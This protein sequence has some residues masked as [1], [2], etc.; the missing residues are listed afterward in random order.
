MSEEHGRRWLHPS[1][2]VSVIS[3]PH[4]VGAGSARPPLDN[5]E[6]RA[7]EV[8]RPYNNTTSRL[9]IDTPDDI[10]AAAY[11]ATQ[12]QTAIVFTTAR[13]ETEEVAANLIKIA[14]ER[15]DSARK[16]N[17]LVHHGSL[18]NTIR[19]DVE[20]RLKEEANLTVCATTTMELG[21]DIGQMSR[22]VQIGAPFSVSSFVQRLGRSGRRGKLPEMA[23]FIQPVIPVGATLAVARNNI[24]VEQRATARV[25]PTKCIPE[26][27]NFELLQIIA[28]VELHLRENFIEPPRDKPL[29]FSL[30]FQQTL[31]ILRSE[32]ELSPS[33]LARRVLTLP[34]FSRVT[35]EHFRTLLSSMRKQNFVQLT[36]EGGILVGEKGAI[37]TE[38]FKFYATFEDSSDIQVHSPD[39]VIGTLSDFPPEGKTFV[40]GGRIWRAAQVDMDSRKVH[41]VPASGSPETLWKGNSLDIHPRIVEK[42]HDILLSDSDVPYLLENARAELAQMREN[43]ANM[44]SDELIEV[45]KSAVLPKPIPI[46]DDYIPYKDKFDRYLPKS[47]LKEQLIANK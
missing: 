2:R 24:H 25:A 44:D 5:I 27:L 39:G 32:G 9:L 34:P 17:I 38:N 46:N 41:A 4:P 15:G 10:P 12:N 43:V 45:I 28:I 47:L 16:G 29:P 8:G 13:A 31:A 14:T 7:T 30:L 11:K 42:M 37:L 1:E 22:I 40:I 26:F 33:D 36:D 3:L 20:R 35:K 6:P 21:I 23:V 18:S 19:A